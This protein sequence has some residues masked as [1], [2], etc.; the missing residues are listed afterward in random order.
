MRQPLFIGLITLVFLLAI[1]LFLPSLFTQ[2]V[3]EILKK[4]IN[5]RVTADVTFTDANINLWRRFP[6]F[7]V[8]LE[9]FVA[10]GRNEFKGDTLVRMK[11]L[12]VVV[13]SLEFLFF[14]EIEIRELS[15]YE[16]DIHIL[17]HQ[18]GKA[19]YQ[20]FNASRDSSETAESHPVKL[21]FESLTIEDG[22]YRYDDKATNLQLTGEGLA[23]TGNGKIRNEV[24]ELTIEADTRKFSSIYKRKPW[25]S[26]KD[27]LLDLKVTYDTKT[28]LFN[29]SDNHIRVN[30]L[31]LAIDGSYRKDR[32]DHIFDLTFRS[33]DSEFRDLLSISNVLFSDFRK[34]SVKGHFSLD[35]FVKG[36]YS[37]LRGVSP[38]FNMNLKVDDGMLKYDGLPSSLN[39]IHFDL[40]AENRD[41]IFDHTVLDLKT[42]K[43]NFGDNPVNGFA[44][45]TGLTNGYIES[46]IIASI[47][48]ED[49]EQIYPMDSISLNGKLNFDLKAD[50]PF[51]GALNSF[52][53]PKTSSLAKT[54]VPSFQLALNLS[55]GV[56]KYEHLPEAISDI[57]FHLKAK[58][59]TGTLDDTSISIE[60]LQ[61]NLGNHPV[62]G[63]VHLSGFRNPYISSELKANL[64]FSDIANFLPLDDISL[65]GLF[66]CDMKISGQLSDSLKTFPIIDAK[67]KLE[68]GSIKSANYPHPVENTHLIVEAT[69]QT[70][71][72][73]D[74]RLNIDTLTYSIEGESFFVKGVVSDLEKFNYDLSVKGVIYLDKLK[75]IL[76]LQD[77]NMAGE[78]D[79][80]LTASGNYPDLVSKKY[81]RLPTTGQVLMTKLIFQSGEFRQGL[82]LQQGHFYFSNENIYLDTLHGSIG[83]SRFNVKGHLYNYMAFILHSDE[84]IKGD[85]VFESDYFNLNELMR[86]EKVTR[87]DSTHHHLQIL[88]FPRNIDFTFD[89]DI[90]NL[91]YK[92][93]T[94]NDLKGEIILRDG[95]LTVR[96]TA[97][98]A[99]DAD[100]RIAGSYDPRDLNHPMFDIDV[101]IHELDITKAHDAFVTV[102][103]VAPAAEHTYGMFSVDYKLKG[104]LLTNLYP[105]F[106]SVK[107]GGTVRIREAKINGMKLFHHISGMTKKEELLNPMLKD[108]VM[109]TKVESGTI[110]VKPFSMKLAGFDT[111]IEGKHDMSGLMSYIVRIALPP[112]DLVKIPLHINGTYD[113]PKIHLGKGHED[114]FAKSIGLNE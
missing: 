10:A 57:N 46:D 88:G 93:L 60:K 108:I 1:V 87:N 99:L 20:I 71:R 50:G 85:L 63:F 2:Q 67:L 61:A 8:T 5:E 113:N 12:H 83:E 79:I 55:D 48:L 111:D 34:L 9:N 30:H 70:G 107:G 74:T 100:F 39:N 69:N 38:A 73:R 24:V 59:T 26:K 77:V 45:I 44:R 110:Y 18:N 56:F 92:N 97:F 101:S 28:G 95:V 41:S 102:Q 91:L 62:K 16:P 19:N 6:R 81:H 40:M 21:E 23:L 43:M 90:S 78:I 17:I 98:K 15:L 103:T 58:N 106:E 25:I 65:K 114:A 33:A 22:K 54:A 104:E 51:T 64:D 29:F 82:Q 105:V 42:F 84:K 96:E 36:T 52:N 89:T 35:G 53:F 13:G 27:I 68:N 76:D 37:K 31:Q 7:T 109:E 14:N 11:E 94:V 32:H 66:D 86:S 3:S 80:D 49:L 112:F 4:Q 75:K 72:I 47:A